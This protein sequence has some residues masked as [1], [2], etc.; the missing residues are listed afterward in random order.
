M[1]GIFLGLVGIIALLPAFAQNRIIKDPDAESRAVSGFHAIRVSTGVVLILTQGKEE[2]VAVSAARP[3]DRNRI[4]TIVEDGV[5]KIYYENN[6]L[7]F[8]TNNMRLKAYVS[9]KLLDGLKA[10]SGARV[11]IDGTLKSN[12]LSLDFSSGSGFKGDISATSLKI[13]QGS[14]ST[15]TISGTANNLYA[16]GSSGSALHAFDLQSGEC[17]AR[18]SSGAGLDISVEKSLRATAHSGGRIYYRGSGLISS[19]DTGSGGSVSKK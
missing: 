16:E 8:T 18:A 9:C 10:S 15:A 11:E 1:K 12:D 17:E 2:A 4:K 7:S 6:N 14:G 3:E 13:Q 5:L 19:V